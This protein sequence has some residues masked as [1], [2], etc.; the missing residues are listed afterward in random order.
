[1]CFSPLGGQCLPGISGVLIY[2]IYKAPI[3]GTLVGIYVCVI[4]SGPGSEKPVLVIRDLN[5]GSRAERFVYLRSLTWWKTV[6]G[7]V[8]S[9][10]PSYQFHPIPWGDCDCPVGQTD[11]NTTQE[12][13]LLHYFLNKFIAQPHSLQLCSHCVLYEA[14]TLPNL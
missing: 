8:F 12:L 3:P 2:P 14:V 13:H 6:S 10:W 11:C 7:Q 9:P 1:M 4:P 5:S